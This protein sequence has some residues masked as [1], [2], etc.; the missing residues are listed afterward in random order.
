MIVFLCSCQEQPLKPPINDEDGPA[1]QLKIEFSIDEMESVTRTLTAAQES[2]V[3][4]VNIYLYHK[5][6]AISKHLYVSGSTSAVINLP[7]GDYDLYVIA[8]RGYDI[9]TK[10]KAEMDAFEITIYS[11]ADL[12]QN[13]SLMMSC[14]RSISVA[15]A[16]TVSVTLKRNVAKVNLSLSVAPQV[17][18]QITIKSIS[19]TNAPKRT[20][21][22]SPNK[23][24]SPADV[25]NYPVKGCSNSYSGSFY[26]FENAQGQVSSIT[27]QNR[28]NRDS[29]PAYATY[30]HIQGDTPSGKVDYFI[31]LGENNTTDFNTFANKEYNIAINIYGTNIIDWRVSFTSAEVVPFDNAYPP[32]AAA[33]G[34]I[35][36]SCSNNSEN[37]FYVSYSVELGTGTVTIDGVDRPANTPFLFMNGSGSKTA[38]VTY[39]QNEAGNVALVFYFTDKYGYT[40]E[41]RL[42][43]SYIIRNPLVTSV[44]AV[45]ASTAH[46]D[47]PLTLSIS[48]L[49]YTNLFDV[50]FEL[51]AG[52]GVLSRGNTSFNS[53]E[54]VPLSGGSHNLSF[55]ATQ[56]GTTQLRFTVTD[57]YGQ[58][59]VEYV[60]FTVTPF[61]VAITLGYRVD[62]TVK[63]ITQ[64][65]YSGQQND[66][67]VLNVTAVSSVAMPVNVTMN[68]TTSYGLGYYATTA[69]YTVTPTLKGVTFTLYE[70][71]ISTSAVVASYVGYCMGFSGSSRSLL[72]TGYFFETGRSGYNISVTLT[73]HYPTSSHEG[74]IEY[75]ITIT[76]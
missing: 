21:L 62:A 2:A 26:L 40:I 42:T 35:T 7:E 24:G 49:D 12:E 73:S 13:A 76:P 43:T 74:S 53:G 5:T 64:G 54:T 22:F 31:Y 25:L 63:T 9:G 45:P 16:S 65:S 44:S 61:R 36:L 68:V 19:I 48:E 20:L 55:R 52:A 69:N 58:E 27:D 14:H 17:S 18:D 34:S 8:N 67:L 71:T 51:T 72:R 10:S 57:I 29:A 28:K 39:R 56:V 32:G 33:I 41:R 59:R 4:D 70:G 46:T 66:P 3:R 6:T 37:Q 1:A 38:N 75:I 15:G 60:T 47:I 11:E 50:K 23:S 30:I